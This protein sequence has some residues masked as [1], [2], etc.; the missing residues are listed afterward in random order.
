MTI[1]KTKSDFKKRSFRTLE[2]RER[3]V[4]EHENYTD[5]IRYNRQKKRY[6]KVQKNI[7]L[8]IPYI[9][10]FFDYVPVLVTDFKDRKIVVLRNKYTN[11]SKAGRKKRAFDD[12][13]YSEEFLNKYHIGKERIWNNIYRVEFIDRESG[14]TLENRYILADETFDRVGLGEEMSHEMFIKYSD[15]LT[16]GHEYKNI[17]LMIFKTQD[18]DNRYSYDFEHIILS[19]GISL[20]D[21]KSSANVFNDLNEQQIKNYRFFNT[22][23]F[24]TKFSE[25]PTL[26]VYNNYE[27]Y[28]FIDYIDGFSKY[29]VKI[30]GVVRT[31]QPLDILGAP[32]SDAFGCRFVLAD[33]EYFYNFK[34]NSTG[35]SIIEKNIKPRPAGFVNGL[36][37]GYPLNNRSPLYSKGYY[38]FENM[39][40]TVRGLSRRGSNWREVYGFE[41]TPLYFEVKKIKLEDN[42]KGIITHFITD[43]DRD[44]RLGVTT[45]NK[46]GSET[47]KIS[48]KIHLFDEFDETLDMFLTSLEFNLSENFIK[49]V[50]QLP[51]TSDVRF[52]HRI[53]SA[54]YFFINGYM[55][56]DTILLDYFNYI[57][58]NSGN[59]LFVKKLRQKNL[60]EAVKDPIP[61]PLRTGFRRNQEDFINHDG[62]ARAYNTVHQKD[63]VIFTQVFRQYYDYK[64]EDLKV[65]II[66]STFD[67]E[68]GELKETNTSPVIL[69]NKE[70]YRAFYFHTVAKNFKYGVITLTDNANGI[71][72][73]IFDDEYEQPVSLSK[74]I[75]DVL[76][77]GGFDMSKVDIS[78]IEA[79]DKDIRGYVI[80]KQ[81]SLKDNLKQIAS[82]FHI[83]AS[84]KNGIIHLKNL[85]NK[86]KCV[87]DIKKLGSDFYS[88]KPV[89]GDKVKID[90]AQ[91]FEIPRRFSLSFIDENREYQGNIAEAFSS[92]TR[93][94]IDKA[95]STTVSLSESEAQKIINNFMVQ[96]LN[97]R[98][99]VKFTTDI[100]YDFL[101][102]NDLI[103]IKN[104]LGVGTPYNIIKKNKDKVLI[105]FECASYSPSEEIPEYELKSDERDFY[106]IKDKNFINASLV[107]I[108]SL[109]SNNRSNNVLLIDKDFEEFDDEENIINASINDKAK[110]TVDRVQMIQVDNFSTRVIVMDEVKKQ[111]AIDHESVIVFS[112]KDN[113]DLNIDDFFEQDIQLLINNPTAN[114]I[115]YNN[116]VMRYTTVQ[117]NNGTVRLSGFIRYV[118]GFNTFNSTTFSFTQNEKNK[119]FFVLLEDVLLSDNIDVN[120]R[121]EFNEKDEKIPVEINVSLSGDKY[122]PLDIITVDTADSLKLYPISEKNIV[123]DQ[124]E[125]AVIINFVNILNPFYNKEDLV[126]EIKTSSI[127]DINYEDIG[128]VKKITNNRVII[129]GVVK[130]IFFNIRYGETK[131]KSNIVKISL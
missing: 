125:N 91:D 67:F 30:M 21:K 86:V 56:K 14:G 23:T 80:N 51:Y 50:M 61:L 92:A 120:N 16:G 55:N 93:S 72:F 99:M 39:G 88:E 58:H 7:N 25:E 83:H 71:E 34:V 28:N 116:E 60:I 82:I 106:Q 22:K 6:K 101:E 27:D 112:L 126:Y 62:T 63:S 131:L 118:K 109:I 20:N 54:P 74:L 4:L 42:T 117:K 124:Q 35:K 10:N 113:P 114:S 85:D 47:V 2:D 52:S 119:E 73:S 123:V 89:L 24:N 87:F 64:N 45:L 66:K 37:K 79:N 90:R 1:E 122:Y 13:I 110:N 49:K 96:A 102:I 68:T 98:E 107:N 29:D 95:V 104:E 100:R 41:I 57:G 44:I 103:I 77:D 17:K 40:D 11:L 76:L 75:K 12:M 130:T 53:H 97:G 15:Y 26:D 81:S 69:Y 94:K 48:R 19:V 9:K 43:D 31:K 115:I 18:Y 111:S 78:D 46:D 33:S 32:A 70:D 59:Q 121:I 127:A 128:E 84:E 129:E 108:P 65:D 105:K 36:G 38:T 8:E 3:V 5:T